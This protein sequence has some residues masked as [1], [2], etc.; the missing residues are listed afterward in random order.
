MAGP[1]AKAPPLAEVSTGAAINPV[2]KTV[3]KPTAI[4]IVIV[5]FSLPGHS[6]AASSAIPGA[7]DTISPKIIG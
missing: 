5:M 6:I 7:L 2:A 4:R 3:R 1:P